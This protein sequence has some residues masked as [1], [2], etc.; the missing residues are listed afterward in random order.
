MKQIIKDLQVVKKN[1]EMLS[2]K[3]EGMQKQLEKMEKAQAKKKTGKTPKVAKR[4]TI[5]KEVVVQKAQKV[6]ASKTILE[7]IQNNRSKKGVDTAVL[8]EKSGFPER[9]IWNVINSLK[10]Q[11]KIKSAGRGYYVEA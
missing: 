4:A 5:A 7:I 6:S 9:K 11:G 8:K 1:L 10:S 3:T 2:K